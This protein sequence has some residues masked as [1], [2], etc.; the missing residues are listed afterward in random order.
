MENIVYNELRRRGFDV[1]VGII[2]CRVMVKGVS[3]YKEYEVD[4]VANKGP[5]RYY[6]QSAFS[7][8]DDEKKKQETNPLMLIS[9][10]FRKFII[11]GDDVPRNTDENGIVE[12]NI[13]DFLTDENSLN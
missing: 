8:P 7:I 5:D 2:K 1:D 3:E 11:T 10:S 6:I 9:D 4:F 12:M 13:I